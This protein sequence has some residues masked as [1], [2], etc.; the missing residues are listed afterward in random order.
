MNAYVTNV[1]IATTNVD[2]DT[3]GIQNKSVFKS[4]FSIRLA[5]QKNAQNKTARIHNTG[6]VLTTAKAPSPVACCSLMIGQRVTT[7]AMKI[8]ANPLRITLT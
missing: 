1:T 3:V 7:H 2:I 5:H 6:E 4:V 8:A